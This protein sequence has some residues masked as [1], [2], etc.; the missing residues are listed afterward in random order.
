MTARRYPEIVENL[1]EGLR[2]TSD[3]L[4]FAFS[5]S[6][7]IAKLGAEV[8]EAD[9]T[10]GAIHRCATE[11]VLFELGSKSSVYRIGQSSLAKFDSR[12]RGDVRIA[13]LLRELIRGLHQFDALQSLAAVSLRPGFTYPD[14]TSSE[15]PFVRMRGVFHPLLEGPVQNDLAIYGDTRLIFLTGPNMAGKSTFM[16]ACGLV[17]L[18]AHVGMAVPAAFASVSLFDRL[19]A[20][21]TV[22][23]SVAGGQSYFLAEVR[24]VRSLVDFAVAGQSMFVLIDEVFKGTNVYDARDA[25]SAV[26]R[27]LSLAPNLVT[28]IASHIVEVAETLDDHSSI[29][30]A[31]FEAFLKG[32]LVEFSFRLIPGVSEQRVGW[33][34]LEREGVVERLKMLAKSDPRANEH[35]NVINPRNSV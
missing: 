26:V 27:G 30:F 22:R 16:K 15:R 32:S 33:L 20:A 35:G 31:C 6:G 19:F 13:D 7:T 34:L 1:E 3:L 23:D 11:S 9:E 12:V 5:L 21:F 28:L 2:A 25:T 18:F 4:Q 14:V 10:L 24:R 29:E 8:T 17:V